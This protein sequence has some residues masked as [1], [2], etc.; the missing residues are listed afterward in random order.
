[1]GRCFDDLA[2]RSRMDMLAYVR[3]SYVR[4]SPL[5]VSVTT[6]VAFSFFPKSATNASSSAISSPSRSSSWQAISFPPIVTM[7]LRIASR[8]PASCN[9]LGESVERSMTTGTSVRGVERGLESR[10]LNVDVPADAVNAPVS[11]TSRRGSVVFLIVI[12]RFFLVWLLSV[13]GAGAAC[14]RSGS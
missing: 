4:G 10:T 12:V 14:Q 3:G 6:A 13:G 8:P 1:M 7:A 5:S 11:R 2:L 9:R